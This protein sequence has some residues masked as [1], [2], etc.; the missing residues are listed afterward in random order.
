MVLVVFFVKQ[1]TAYEMRISDWS[2][3][4]CSS[5]LLVLARTPDA[6]AGTKGISL[7]IVPKYRIDAKGNIGP[8]NDVRCASIEHKLGIH[9]SPTCV[10]SYG[11][12]DECIG[13]L[14]GSECAGMKAMFT[15]MNQARL[16]VGSQ[17]VQIGE[18][19][20]QQALAYAAERIQSAPADG[21]SPQPAAIIAH[22]DV[23]RML[24]RMKALTQ[25]ARALVYYAAGQVD[26]AQLGLAGA[27][28]RLDLLTPLAKA[29]GTDVGCEVIGRAQV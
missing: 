13:E 27:K 5:D 7:F 15:M 23:R 18:R 20:T 12:Q 22:P 17:G 9:A 28:K 29:Y 24:V 4:V 26:R 19:A 2:S 21:S 11:D 25:A 8:I 16:N 14:I 1:K 10:M 6:P 3:D